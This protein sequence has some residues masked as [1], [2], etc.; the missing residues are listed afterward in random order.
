MAGG[1][2]RRGG[3]PLN[4]RVRTG[5]PAEPAPPATRHCWVAEPDGGLARYPGLLVRW[6]RESG[7]FSAWVVYLLPEPDTD[8]VRIV[9]RWLPAELLTA[10]P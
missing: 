9:E 2:G 8:D 1:M 6:R 5:A 4:E 10:R 7:G 3:P